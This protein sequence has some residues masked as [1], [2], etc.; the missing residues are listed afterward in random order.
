[1]DGHVGRNRVVA[2]IFAIGGLAGL[3]VTGR[4]EFLLA[5]GLLATVFVLPDLIVGRKHDGE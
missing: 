5:G 3:L 1:M 4:F 2:G